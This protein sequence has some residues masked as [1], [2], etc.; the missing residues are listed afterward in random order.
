M[1]SLFILVPVLLLTGCDPV[2][3][4]DYRPV[5]HSSSSTPRP[6]YNLHPVASQ[7]ALDDCVPETWTACIGMPAKPYQPT[8]FDKHRYASDGL[9]GY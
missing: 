4:Y 2:P 1:R 8:E 5:R 3:V 9:I 6:N 7:K